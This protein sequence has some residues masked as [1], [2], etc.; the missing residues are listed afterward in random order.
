MECIAHALTFTTEHANTV[1]GAISIY[2]SWLGLDSFSLRPAVIEENEEFYQRE[3]LMH[4]SLLFDRKASEFDSEHSEMCRSALSI[5]RDFVRVKTLSEGTWQGL[6]KLLL[7]IVPKQRSKDPDFHQLLYA[8]LFEIWLR[9]NTRDLQLWEEL[10]ALCEGD[11]LNEWLIYQWAS[12]AEALTRRVVKI[13]YGN[14][15]RLV[16][17]SFKT[18]SGREQPKVS[19]ELPY[20]QVLYYWFRVLHLPLSRRPRDPAIYS[21]LCLAVDKIVD[22]FLLVCCRRREKKLRPPDFGGDYK[23]PALAAMMRSSYEQHSDYFLGQRRLPIPSADAL[24]DLLGPWL[25]VNAKAVKGPF[26]KG[27]AYS[28]RTLCKIVCQASGPV[29]DEHLKR[30]YGLVLNAFESQVELVTTE[31]FINCE[32][33]FTQDHKGVLSLIVQERVCR[34]LV[35][36]FTDQK[37]ASL[38][39]ACVNIAVAVAALPL[40]YADHEVLGER[41]RV[42]GEQLE[43]LFTQVIKADKRTDFLKKVVWSACVFCASASVFRPVEK[44]VEAMLGK[45]KTLDMHPDRDMYLELL[46]VFTTLPFLLMPRGFKGS[47]DLATR[48]V[49]TLASLIM[50]RVLDV[51]LQP[52]YFAILHWLACFPQVAE[53]ETT[54]RQIITVLKDGVVNTKHESAR[55]ALR[56]ILHSLGRELSPIKA[57]PNLFIHLASSS[58]MLR[59]PDMQKAGKYFMLGTDV[60]VSLFDT[61]GE[62]EE[63]LM[64]IRDMFGRYV[65]KAQLVYKSNMQPVSDTTLHIRSSPSP[66][67]L[68]RPVSSVD[69]ELQREFSE[70]ALLT[71]SQVVSSMTAQEQT[72]QQFLS[73]SA[74]KKFKGPLAFLSTERVPKAHRLFLAQLGFL[75]TNSLSKILALEQRTIAELVHDLDTLNERQVYILP[76]IYLPHVEASSTDAMSC[77]HDYSTDFYEFLKTLGVPLTPDSSYDL[78]ENLEETLHEYGAALYSAGSH[79]ELLTVTPALPESSLDGLRLSSFLLHKTVVVVWNARTTD[80]V[81]LKRPTLLGSYEFDGIAT[82]VITPLRSK[83]YK[84]NINRDTGPL[85][86][87][88]LVPMALLS[89]LV[90]HTVINLSK[91]RNAKVLE[92]VRGRK[93]L[94]AQVYEAGAELQD[95]LPNFSALF[96][97]AFAH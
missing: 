76:L 8:T 83:L 71:H 44:L 35:A 46:E 96:A 92:T 56:R 14:D 32:T 63:V 38:Q 45:L 7:L 62:R 77:K 13:I 72:E 90:T 79:Y 22:C 24:L 82:I 41:Y 12:L 5:Y 61:E 75:T 97:Y 47:Q 65:W 16:D 55:Y 43:I 93:Q 34:T 67:R 30:F 25:Y 58:Q 68:P 10:R 94:L 91:D 15:K 51:K 84:V 49:L 80:R 20:E 86:D 60:L 50:G 48:V 36:S 85:Q 42:L 57:G 26:D 52:L 21:E 28:V 53:D 73:P 23:L 31:I 78:F 89:P 39:L 69:E 54:R 18:N 33:L 11:E 17:I 37:S 1:R 40:Y 3:I 4:L 88:M 95:E 27:Q 59:R 70:S 66:M 29:K 2:K 64:V 87:N 19:V 9:S 81:S 74:A 6:V